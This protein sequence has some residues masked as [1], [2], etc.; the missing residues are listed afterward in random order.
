[1]PVYNGRLYLT[2]AV[3][4]VLVQ[5]LADFELIAIDDGSTDGSATI[6]ERMAETDSRIVVLRQSNAGAT[7]AMNV[8]VSRARGQFVARMDA[9]DVCRPRRFERQIEFLGSH[10]DHVAVG[11]AVL[12]IDPEG[13]PLCVS[14]WPLTHEE[15][16]AATLAGKSI[17]GLAHPAA[18]IS[19]ASLREV[20]GYREK[21]R[22]AQDK[23]LWLRLAEVGRL[24]NL[25]DVLLKYRFHGESTGARR[26]AEQQA[27]FEEAIADACRRRGIAMPARPAAR[28]PF[29]PRFPE[30]Q[31]QLAMYAIS[32]CN[33][34]TARRHAWQFW[35][36]NPLCWRS[37]ALAA[38]ALAAPLIQRLRGK[39]GATL[40]R[41]ESLGLTASA[42]CR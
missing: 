42:V 40:Q 11:S 30:P 19:T 6:L 36:E 5:T 34:S 39:H 3:Q 28:K 26:G 37:W 2:E 18:M 29:L 14:R 27:A 41:D 8:G 24:A 25:P 12:M 32:G 15:L 17:G 22:V 33:F 31:A 9:D 16:D 10:P 1:M 7:R 13:S 23:D 21:F 35:R 20:G 38:L 4:S